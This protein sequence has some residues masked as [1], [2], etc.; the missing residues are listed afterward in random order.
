[1]AKRAR[2]RTQPASSNP[3]DARSTLPEWRWRTFPVFFAFFAG[4]LL[5]AIANGTPDNSLAAVAQL[6]AL[7]GL[8]YGFARLF[9]RKV[10][11]ERRLQRRAQTSE[12]EYEDVAVYPNEKRR[13]G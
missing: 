2:R 1:M 12:D 8:S 5:M 3:P 11:A 6:I 7:A 10:F 9:V 13:D 4:A